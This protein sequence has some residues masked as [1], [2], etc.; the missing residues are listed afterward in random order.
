MNNTY[1]IAYAEVLEILRYLP[2]EVYI[3]IPK[4]KIRFYEK[5]KDKSHK[6]CYD[7]NKSLD[8]QNISRKTKIIIISLFKDFFSTETQK[9]NI[10]KILINNE[11]IYQD[12]LRKRYNPDNIFKNEIK[13][14][15]NENKLEITTNKKDNPFLTI[16]NRIKKLFMK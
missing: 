8:E 10:N 13:D 16:I 4:E 12:K 2:T 3:K 5:N 15:N 9:E 6:F 14:N 11:K 7:V 1:G